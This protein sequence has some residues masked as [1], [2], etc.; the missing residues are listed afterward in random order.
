M[1][2]NK[3]QTIPQDQFLTMAA[4]LLYKGF[5]ESSRTRSKNIYKELITGKVLPLTTIE[6]ADKSTVRFDVA[7]DHSEYR[8]SINFGAF[9]AS[10]TQLIAS[11]GESLK[12]E[13][14]IPVFSAEQDSNMMI[15][16]VTSITQDGQGKQDPNIMVLGADVAADR[17]FVML[18]LMYIDHRQFI[19]DA[20]GAAPEGTA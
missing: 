9:R 7:L 18:K 10:L 13:D 11:L 8:G 3:T 19:V 14:K 15:F 12:K 20:D 2:V 4:N 17:P 1:S 16:G 5:L 6:M